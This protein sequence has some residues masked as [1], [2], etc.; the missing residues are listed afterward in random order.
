MSKVTQYLTSIIEPLTA[1]IL[2]GQTTSDIVKFYGSTLKTIILPAS[3]DGTSLT[4]KVSY[5]GISFFDYYNVNNI[6]VSITCT[7][8]RAYGVL[9][10]DFNSIYALK[11]VSNASETADRSIIL[12]PRSYG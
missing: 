9:A 12:L 4:F 1:I 2:S 7:A 6:Q 5:D 8:G 3:F 10:N 11:I